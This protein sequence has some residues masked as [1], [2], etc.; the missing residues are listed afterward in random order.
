MAFCAWPRRRSFLGGLMQFAKDKI[1]SFLS[2]RIK[3]NKFLIERNHEKNQ[4]Y[5]EL[6]K[7]GGMWLS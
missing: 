1:N 5:F 7:E 6:L 3:R 4:R 2:L